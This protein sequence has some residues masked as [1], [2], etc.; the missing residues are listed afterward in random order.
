MGRRE[1]PIITDGPV[2]AFATKLRK[3]RHE[4]GRKYA[5]MAK[6]VKLS[7]ASLS[8]AASG[9]KLP[10]WPTAEKYIRACGVSD[11][12]EI[13]QW[14]REWEAAKAHTQAAKPAAPPAPTGPTK[15]TKPCLVTPPTAARPV[16]QRLWVPAQRDVARAEREDQ[17]DDEPPRPLVFTIELPA[18]TLDHFGLRHDY[19]PRLPPPPR[20]S[21]PATTAD[22]VGAL[23]DLVL[24]QGYDI[25]RRPGPG[26]RVDRDETA[27]GLWRCLHSIPV[28]Q[29]LTGRQRPVLGV[30][31]Q[32]VRA[33]GG[34]RVDLAE[35]AR[36]WERI[37]AAEQICPVVTLPGQEI[38]VPDTEVAAGTADQRRG[39]LLRDLLL[40]GFGVLLGVAGTLLVGWLLA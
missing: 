34:S 10:P 1:N 4:R 32:V 9:K 23:N 30:V 33:C 25:S 29:V 37:Q 22:L 8:V 17:A 27:D 7:A 38:A 36:V 35:W 2:G 28:R 11:E 14:R 26:E 16:V 20:L 15:A 31:L 21:G 40:V 39:R 18:L 13:A 19:Q 12:A 5:T 3:L 24:R 6:A